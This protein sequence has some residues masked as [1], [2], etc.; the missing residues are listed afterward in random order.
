[1][2]TATTRTRALLFLGAALLALSPM[3]VWVAEP[4]LTAFLLAAVLAIALTPATAR[5]SARTG[6][7]VLSTALV[8]VACVLTIGA[9]MVGAGLSISAELST[10]YDALNRQS[11]EEGGWQAFATHTVD[12]VVDEVAARLPINRDVLRTELMVRLTRSTDAVLRAVGSVLGG[13]TSALVDGFLVTLFLYFLLR[14][15]GQWVR[16]VSRMVPLETDATERL[17]SAVRDSAIANVSGVIVV[18]VGQGILLTAAFWMVGLH[19]PV[20]WGSIGGLASVVPVLGPPVIWVPVAGGLLVT[21]DYTRALIL[22]GWGVVVVGS[23]DN[24]IRPIV[25]GSRDK[26]HPMLVGLAAIGGTVAFG[27]LGILLG[28]ILVSL[29]AALVREIVRQASAPDAGQ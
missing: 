5:L 22:V 19:A 24:I 12:R 15:G 20:L 6:R 17:L 23:F 27:P 3:L 2:T 14:Y 16:Y 11:V 25:V 4:F 21:G 7:P 8:T 1:M 10:A 26:Q 29:C 18:A 9:L 13:A 28:P